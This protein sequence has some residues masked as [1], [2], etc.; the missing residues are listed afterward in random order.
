MI[1]VKAAHTATATSPRTA[2]RPVG[3]K[4][5]KMCVNLRKLYQGSMGSPCASLVGA[6]GRSVLRKEACVD[7]RRFEAP[8]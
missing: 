6:P 2:P 3:V 1:T 7:G 4:G 8:F 5:M